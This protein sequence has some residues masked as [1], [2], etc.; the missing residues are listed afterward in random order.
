[1]KTLTLAL[2]LAALGSAQ[3]VKDYKADPSAF[4]NYI[5]GVGDGMLIY[6]RLIDGEHEHAGLFPGAGAKLYCQ[7][8][9]LNALG[10]QGILES[11][12]QRYADKELGSL[13]AMPLSEAMAYAMRTTFPCPESKPVT[14]NK[15]K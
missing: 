12:I 2:L 1:M 11:W 13:D 7:P 4:V 3:T 10:Y 5:K 15:G 8:V 14:Q 9:G 6:N